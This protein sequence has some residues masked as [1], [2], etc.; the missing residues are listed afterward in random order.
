V[1]STK[2]RIKYI[3]LSV[4]MKVTPWI[5]TRKGQRGTEAHH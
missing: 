4:M 1:T 3:V 2:L 5:G